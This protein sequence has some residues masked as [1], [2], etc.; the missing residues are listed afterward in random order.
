M[1]DT[2]GES[3]QILT[4]A[5]YDF[6]YSPHGFDFDTLS[7]DAP[8]ITDENLDTYNAPERSQVLYEYITHQASHY[9][10]N[11]IFVPMGGDFHFQNA[12]KFFSSSDAMIDYWNQNML[13]ATNIELIYSTPSMYIDALASHNIEWPTKYDDM[14]PYADNDASYW[15]GYFSSRPNDKK[16]MRDAS[17]T[18]HSSNK[19][20]ALASIDQQTTDTEI[21]Q[22]LE[23]KAAMM[24]VVGVVQHHDG[25][26]GTGKQHTADDYVHRI[27]KGIEATNPVYSDVIDKIAK[28]AGIE[29]ENWSW[30]Q[31][32]NGTWEDCPIAEYALSQDVTMVVSVHNPANL[33]MKTVEIKVPHKDFVA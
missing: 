23:A 18:L 6:Y 5:F 31:R 1:W 24:D 28:S 26:T 9:L 21:D 2:L 30:C 14:F 20:F 12:H 32:Q 29:A 4:H 16:Y 15:T 10:T 17:H 22:M 25:I 7:N 27:F 33:A 3:T 8:F 13:E 11:D 19:L